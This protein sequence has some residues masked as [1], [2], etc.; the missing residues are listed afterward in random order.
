VF[1]FWWN[2]IGF[3]LTFGIGFLGSKVIPPEKEGLEVPILNE[4]PQFGIWQT[5]VLLAFFVLI[6]A[7]SI[8]L[9]FL[10]G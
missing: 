3:A 1:W 6:L 5:W 7:V 10:I 4:K 8:G 9:P 2:L